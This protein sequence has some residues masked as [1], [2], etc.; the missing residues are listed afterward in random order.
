VELEMRVARELGLNVDSDAA[1]RFKFS[2]TRQNALDDQFSDSN[3]YFLNVDFGDLGLRNS[4]HGVTFR[5]SD[6]PKGEGGD[7]G[8]GSERLWESYIH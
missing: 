8:H 3:I 2:I 1:E 5:K 4:G 7:F 6:F